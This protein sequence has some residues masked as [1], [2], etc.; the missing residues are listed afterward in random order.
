MWHSI[1]TKSV[2]R[3]V[4]NEPIGKN[5][6]ESDNGHLPVSPSD[7]HAEV[8]I[9]KKFHRRWTSALKSIDS[10]SLSS[11]A[12][13]LRMIATSCG[14]SS[15]SRYR[16]R[17]SNTD[18]T[19]ATVWFGIRWIKKL[20]DTKKIFMRTEH[21]LDSSTLSIPMMVVYGFVTQLVIKSWL[22]RAWWLKGGVFTERFFQSW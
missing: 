18:M 19:C 4:S 1:Q 13:P 10:K 17:W 3:Y 22:G 20:R 8:C 14:K 16:S 12:L 5:I 15:R 21:P 6:I 11:L 2:S 9:N 7:R